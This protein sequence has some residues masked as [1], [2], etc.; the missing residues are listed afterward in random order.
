MSLKLLIERMKSSVYNI[1]Q[2]TRQCNLDLLTSIESMFDKGNKW[3][4]NATG[5]LK[6]AY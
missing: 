3:P 2:Y 6:S 5:A 1:S 4:S